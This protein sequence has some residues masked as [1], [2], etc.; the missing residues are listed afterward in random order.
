MGLDTPDRATAML[1]GDGPTTIRF[2]R[3]WPR[4]MAAELRGRPV[5]VKRRKRS[6]SLT[7]DV[8]ASGAHQLTIGRSPVAAGG[9]DGKG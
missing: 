7:V 5:K 4:G 6:V 1:T 8:G 3:R 9:H 2:T